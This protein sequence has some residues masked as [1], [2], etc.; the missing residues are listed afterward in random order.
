MTEMSRKRKREGPQFIKYFG[1]V[2]QAL[3]D[4]DASARPKEVYDWIIENLEIPEDE[5]A[6]TNKNGQSNFEN[7]VAFARFYLSKAGYIDG[8]TRGVWALTDKGRSAHFDERTALK[9]FDEVQSVWSRRGRPI[10]EDEDTDAAP[11]DD[12]PITTGDGLDA[13]YLNLKEAQEQLA[14]AL[15][16]MSPKGFEEFRARIFRTLGFENVLIRG[17]SGDGGIDGLGELLVNRFL[18]TRVAFQCK[19]Y[20]D[21]SP[22]TPER[23][24]D[25]RGAIA[26]RVDRGIFLTTSRFT[27]AASEEARRENATPIELIDLSQIIEILIAEK[28]GVVE[29][30]ALAI[31][32]EFFLQYCERKKDGKGD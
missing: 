8:S 24:R 26:G 11:D 27:K 23:I 17:G 16:G 28:V 30:K 4:N 9:V 22:I 7:K 12:A 13:D 14:E 29:R 5:L 1:P 21:A 20:G 2:L 18:R 6:K 25:F 19:K 32:G 3:R 15:Q 31:D 10:V